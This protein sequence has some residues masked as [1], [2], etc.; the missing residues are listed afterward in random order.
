[1]A[2]GQERAYCYVTNIEA[3]RLVN[4]VQV[5][6]EADGLLRTEI[7]PQDLLDTNAARRGE[8]E[9]MGKRVSAIPIHL[10]NARMKVGS[11][12]HVGIYPVSH[13]EVTVPPDAPD[14]IGVDVRI[15]LYQPGM[16]REVRL[17]GDGWSFETP[18]EP[19]PYISIERSQDRRSI[20]VI[21]TS[22]RRTPRPEERRKPADPSR[23]ILEVAADRGMVSIYAV[24]ADIRALVRELSKATGVNLTVAADLERTVSVSLDSVRLEDAVECIALTYGASLDGVGGTMYLADGGVADLAAY[25]GSDFAEIPLRHVSAL[26]ARDSLPDVLLGFIHTDDGR[27]TLTVAGPR[28]MVEKVRRDVAVL[29]R[30]APMIEVTAAAV[31]FESRSD[32]SAL[33]EG[34]LNWAGGLM[35]VASGTGDIS[36]SSVAGSTSDLEARVHALI[37]AGRAKLRSQTRATVL[38]G[39]TARLFAGQERRLATQYYDFWTGAFEV[40]ILTLRIG[41]ALDVTPWAA[42]GG[43]VTASVRAEVSTIAETE[44][45]TG[46]PTIAQRAAETTVRLND[47]ETLYIGGLDATQQTDRS[48]SFPG[49]IGSYPDARERSGTRLGVFVSARIVTGAGDSDGRTSGMP[50]TRGLEQDQ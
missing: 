33:I 12:T 29:D 22:D 46:N 1:M 7:D 48:K 15:V 23:S 16:T 3:H 36:Y 21:V 11:I 43:T 6:I 10:L 50:R 40:R 32:L 20:I 39:R 31:E 9:K 27:N 2:R 47:G 45:V 42:G 5:K 28:A 26:A 44:P 34:R 25:H 38:S 24:D 19:P 13:V 8:W 37:G 14:G 18:N 35:D 41:T 49:G 4:A 30:P 17:G